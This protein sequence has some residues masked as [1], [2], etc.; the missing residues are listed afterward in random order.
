M[1]FTTSSFAIGTFNLT[2]VEVNW[3]EPSKLLYLALSLP[4][5]LAV[6][7]L[8]RNFAKVLMTETV[9]KGI[10][11]SVV[12][13]QKQKRSRIEIVHLFHERI[14]TKATQ[15]A[16]TMFNADTLKVEK[17]KYCDIC[18]GTTIRNRS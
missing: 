5:I 8:V 16:Q 9:D 14:S 10:Q 12:L 6:V 18:L 4:W 17:V 11:E 7:G 3:Q 15:Q 13:N 1:V 2:T